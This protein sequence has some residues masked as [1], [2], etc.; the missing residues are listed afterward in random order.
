[1]SREPHPSHVPASRHSPFVTT[2]WSA[3]R[4]AGDGDASGSGEALESLCQAYWQPVYAY[5]R[6]RGYSPEDA[7]DL[8]QGL[9]LDLLSR[10][11]IAKADRGR[12]RFRTFLLAALGNYLSKQSDKSAAAKR[13]S[14]RP[15]LSLDAEAGEEFYQ[16]E[17][18][19][20]FEPEKLFDRRWAHQITG[21]ALDRLKS[22]T[23]TAVGAGAEGRFAALQKYL[24]AEPD[25]GEYENRAGELG[26]SVNG[27]KT[28]V[29]RLRLRFGAILREEVARTVADANEVEAELAHLLGVLSAP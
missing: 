27:V 22:E 25:P 20:G 12:G 9:F 14:G 5:V 16:L 18:G 6:R 23:D 15:L 21:L 17:S 29:R 7:R 2:N 19:D 11:A 3:V 28:A 4:L 1:M 10:D 26:L 24:L 8:T 13:G